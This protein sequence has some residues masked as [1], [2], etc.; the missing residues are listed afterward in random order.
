MKFE[1]EG[2]KS[3]RKYKDFRKLDKTESRKAVNMP[4]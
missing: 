2:T 1:E 4:C 3:K